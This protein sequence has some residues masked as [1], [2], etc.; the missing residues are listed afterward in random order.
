MKKIKIESSI[1]V[2]E[3]LEELPENIQKLFHQAI[4]ARDKAYAPY[5]KFNVG[6]AI[7]M[8]NGEVITGSN[9]ENAAYP[10]GLCAER[11]A[12]FYAGAKFPKET[13]KAIAVSAKS[14]ERVLENPASPC[15]GCR[16]AIAEYEQNQGTPIAMYFM[17]EVGKIV[18]S[19]SLKDLLPLSFDKNYL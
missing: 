18:K 15:G 16:Q 17:G 13:I 7:L 11:T 5:S 10:S 14:L 12:V 19:D 4:V 9:Q 1:S 3:D 2:Y 8:G 6:A